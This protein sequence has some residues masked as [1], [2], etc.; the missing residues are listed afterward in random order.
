MELSKLLDPTEPH[1]RPEIIF[2][3]L[4]TPAAARGPS[5]PVSHF[6]IPRVH[7]FLDLW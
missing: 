1:R 7:I 5:N 6:P 4:R 3:G 2:A